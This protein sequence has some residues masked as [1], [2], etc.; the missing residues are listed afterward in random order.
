MVPSPRQSVVQQPH[1][2]HP[3]SPT[4]EVLNGRGLRFGIVVSRYNQS[5]VHKLLGGARESMLRHGVAEGDLSTIEV[6]GAWEIPRGLSWLARSRTLHGLIALGVIIRGGTPHF[7]YVCRGCTDGCKSVEQELD[8]PVGFGVLTC[9]TVEQAVSRAGGDG[10]NKGEEA[11]VAALEMAN[12]KRS[13]I[14]P[15]IGHL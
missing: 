8:L 4:A 2:K 1:E 6:P 14:M 10:G 15:A 3:G 11:A 9:D 13:L 7:E 12:V 5:I